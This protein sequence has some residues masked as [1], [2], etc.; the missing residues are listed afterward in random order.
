[1]LGFGQLFYYNV[2]VG[3]TL[4]HRQVFKDILARESNSGPGRNPSIMTITT[5]LSLGLPDQS[6]HSDWS[7]RTVVD[8]INLSVQVF[9][10]LGGGLILTFRGSV[11]MASNVDFW[12]N[13]P[14]QCFDDFESHGQVSLFLSKGYSRRLVVHG[15][16][17][18]QAGIVLVHDPNLLDDPMHFTV[19]AFKIWSLAGVCHRIALKVSMQVIRRTFSMEG[20]AAFYRWGRESHVRRSRRN[21]R[22]ANYGR[23]SRGYR[24]RIRRMPYGGGTMNVGVREEM[25]SHI[26]LI[27]GGSGEIAHLIHNL[28][29]LS[30]EKDGGEVYNTLGRLRIF[31]KE[32]AFAGL[33]S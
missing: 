12:W 8:G 23:R 31:L 14:D 1:M 16:M 24:R 2:F 18:Y 7:T 10:L 22:M 13:M 33:D 3:L 26:D 21:P 19:E 9:D 28:A 6:F 32:T 5:T 27:H 17:L 4:K 30:R 20:G 29:I 11:I 15:E 25:G